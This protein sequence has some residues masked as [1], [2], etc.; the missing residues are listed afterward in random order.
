MP[1]LGGD[2]AHPIV[3]GVRDIEV[4]GVIEHDCVRRVQFGVDRRAAVADIAKLSRP[5]PAN[6]AINP[7]LAVTFL[8]T[9]L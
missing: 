1:L 5:F 7:V 2:Q 9:L 3:A 6:V 8:T 4:P